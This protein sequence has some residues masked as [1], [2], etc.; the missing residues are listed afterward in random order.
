MKITYSNLAKINLINIKLYIKQDSVLRANSFIN[1]LKQQVHDIPNF[2]YKFRK[3]DYYNDEDIRDM[4]FH[5]Y[6]I[7]YRI[8]KHKNI[9]E[10]LEIFN[11]NLPQVEE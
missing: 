3:S 10:I 5:G 8:N 6:T 11:Q 1:K 4:I 7:I 9:I 2:P